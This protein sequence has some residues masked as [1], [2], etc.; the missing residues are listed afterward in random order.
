MVGL[1]AL[2]HIFDECIQT[3]ELEIHFHLAGLQPC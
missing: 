1:H 3:H 2:E